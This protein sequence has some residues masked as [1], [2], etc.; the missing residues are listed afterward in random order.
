MIC[1]VDIL[2]AYKDGKFER[3]YY[4]LTPKLIVGACQNPMESSFENEHVAYDV[5]KRIFDEMQSYED[6]GL[7]VTS[8]YC[9]IH[10]GPVMKL[11]EGKLTKNS[12]GT[13]FDK[14]WT[15]YGEEIIEG[16]FGINSYDRKILK[17][18]SY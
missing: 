11:A 5:T 2:Q 1:W 14:L 15:R 6:D 7:I 17:S 8:N 3:Y 4:G 10:N 13:N 12:I 16:N 9:G 18:I